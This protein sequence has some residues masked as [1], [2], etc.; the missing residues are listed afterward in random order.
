MKNRTPLITAGVA[1]VVLGGMWLM[2]NFWGSEKGVLE[3]GAHATTTQSVVVANKP[4]ET[5]TPEESREAYLA[6]YY[7]R[8]MYPRYEIATIQTYD[9]P[10]EGIVGVDGQGQKHPLVPV[11]MLSKSLTGNWAFYYSFKPG[12]D[13]GAWP[14]FAFDSTTDTLRIL[15][16][17]SSQMD[18]AYPSKERLSPDGK[19]YASVWGKGS[20]IND[21]QTFQTLYVLDLE[22]DTATPVKKLSGTE[23]LVKDFNSW[24]DYPNSEVVWVDDH[25]LRYSVFDSSVKVVSQEPDSSSKPTQHPLV[26]VETVSF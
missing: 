21:A 24:A 23:S 9:G 2:Q 25:S 10:Y 19:R 15:K 22:A 8:F 3:T 6:A 14:Y 17:V 12:T 16:T 18:S 4:Q 13:A 1:V 20:T 11:Q 26:R 7:G 5:A